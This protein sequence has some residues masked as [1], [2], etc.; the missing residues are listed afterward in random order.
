[1]ETCSI[2]RV[3]LDTGRQLF[4]ENG[5]EYKDMETCNMKRA[6]LDTGRQ[7]LPENGPEHKSMPMP[8][9]KMK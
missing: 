9:C 8:I 6:L 2:K 5:P 1:M 4:P 7:H 3:L